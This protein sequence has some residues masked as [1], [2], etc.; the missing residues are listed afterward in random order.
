MKLTLQSLEDG[1]MH[2]TVDLQT[3]GEQGL[4]GWAV[5]PHQPGLTVQELQVQVL[6]QLSGTLRTLAHEIRKPE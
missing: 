5:L 1:K 4:Q 3:T 2:V 6:L